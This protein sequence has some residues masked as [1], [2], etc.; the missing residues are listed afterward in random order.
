VGGIREPMIPDAERPRFAAFVAKTFGARARAIGWKPKAK[1]DEQVRLIRPALLLMV[2]DRGED[3]ALAAEAEALARRW[4]DDPKAV[5]SDVIDAVLEVAAQRGDRA[6][7]DR[8]RAEAKKAKD[9]TRRHHLLG[10][11]SAFRD[12]SIVRESLGLLLTNEHDLRDSIVLMFQD[13]RMHDVTYGFVK[14][15]FDALA[16]RL[17]SDFVGDLPDVGEPFC[18][19]EHRA[20][21]AAFFKDRAPKLLGGARN[22]A[23]VLEK[24]HLCA[25]QKREQAPSLT[26]FLSKF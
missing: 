23:K 25:A 14:E 12:P 18:D 1:E 21:V 9:D 15:H 4:L 13:R 7:F 10:A 6:L 17:P 11:M 8:I 16:G 20:D 5:E 2:A 19:E 26:R 22:L 3:R 24:I